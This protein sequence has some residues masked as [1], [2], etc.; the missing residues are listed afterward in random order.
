MRLSYLAK[1]AGWM[2]AAMVRAIACTCRTSFYN[3]RRH[4]LREQGLTYIYAALHAHQLLHIVAGEPGTA[5]MVSRSLDGELSVPTLHVFGY[6]PV[7]GSSR[8]AT[9]EK[10]GREAL[11][12]LKEHLR[13]KRPA[14]L[15]VD[16]PRGPRNRVHMGVCSLSRDT[17]TP[18]LGVVALATRKWVLQR[19]WDRLQIPQPFAT[20]ELYFTDPLTPHEDET[21]AQFRNRIE[22]E[23][24]QLEARLDPEEAQ[25]AA[26]GQPRQPATQ[27]QAA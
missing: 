13:K 11:E 22:A 19:T 17:Q 27:T 8:S 4:Q 16:G 6:I 18:I 15:A 7:R 23:L 26:G 20:I 3:D 9:G 21:I 10:G 12:A 25:L 24:C 14:Y 1:P 5:A 2:I